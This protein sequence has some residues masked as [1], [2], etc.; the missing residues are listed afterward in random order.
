M[1]P[2]ES[3]RRAATHPMDLPEPA[4]LRQWIGRAE[5]QSDTLDAT[6]VRA[7]WATLDHDDAAPAPGDE[8]PALATWMYFVGAARTDRLGPD[9]HAERGGFLPPVE[10]PRRMWAG[11]RLQFHQPLR[12]GDAAQQHARVDDV[13]VRQGRSGAL[14]FVTVRH[15]ICGPRGLAVTELRDIVYRAAPA[16]QAA[17]PAVPQAPRDEEFSRTLR[18]DAVLLFRY[19]ALTF[20]AHRIHY[21][22]GFATDVEGYPGLVVHGPL[23]ATLLLDL[24]RCRHPGQRL[25]R[26]DFR[27]VGP[28][29]DVHAFTL[30]GRADG[31][32]RDAL[33]A[34]DHQ[35][36]LAMQAT[37]GWV[38]A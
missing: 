35:G 16:A 11:S 20:N 12:V 36:R 2:H 29:F 7:L 13:R 8:L 34:R 6:R 33:W 28:L 31:A 27:A 9:G 23:L 30:C 26:F 21:D 3:G 1:N 37:A 38:S 32:A 14:V 18:A 15:E 22:R 17:G 10:L 25:Q 5:Q 19:S 24:V 4:A